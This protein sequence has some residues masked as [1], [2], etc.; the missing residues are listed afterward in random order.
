METF[1]ISKNSLRRQAAG[2]CVALLAVVMIVAYQYGT[3][4]TDRASF[5]VVGVAA[6]IF[7]AYF[8]R[9]Y[10]RT[11]GLALGHSLLLTADA[12]VLHDGAVERRIS[13]S[14]IEQMKVHRRFLGDLW[15]TLHTTSPGVKRLYGYENMN[16]LVQVLASK[17][18]RDRVSGR[19][20]DA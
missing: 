13:Y 10:K 4:R 1:R 9:T 19:L 16:Q 15:F 18:A 20:P 7:A 8:R 17:L 5:L 3:H 6:V 2:F 12:V 11:R 14:S